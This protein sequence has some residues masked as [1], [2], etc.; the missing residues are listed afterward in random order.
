MRISLILVQIL[1]LDLRYNQV[2]W[3][4]TQLEPIQDTSD[5]LK[6]LK[7]RNYTLYCEIDD[8]RKIA[9]LAL[10]F[11]FSERNGH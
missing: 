5:C 2:Y 6:S 10:L 3:L 7:E 8:S 1:S 4:L 9:A 11:R